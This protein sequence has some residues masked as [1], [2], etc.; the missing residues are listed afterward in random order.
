ML[1]QISNRGGKISQCTVSRYSARLIIFL[2][3]TGHKITNLLFRN[4][5]CCILALILGGLQI[6]RIPPAEGR[7][8]KEDNLGEA[9][10]DLQYAFIVCFIV[11]IFIF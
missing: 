4:C 3:G 7:F 10:K 1:L 2:S 6:I 8:E 11:D 9:S 5:L